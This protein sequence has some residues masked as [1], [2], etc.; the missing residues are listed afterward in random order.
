MRN[1]VNGSKISGLHHSNANP[2]ECEKRVKKVIVGFNLDLNLDSLDLT[3]VIT[4]C[5]SDSYKV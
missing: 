3:L 5:F 1:G 4:M 2:I